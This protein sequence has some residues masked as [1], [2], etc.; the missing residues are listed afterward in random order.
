MIRSVPGAGGVAAI[1]VPLLAAMAA[2]IGMVALH[3]PHALSSALHGVAM[4]SSVIRDGGLDPVAAV[5]VMFSS[6][7]ALSSAALNADTMHGGPVSTGAPRTDA[8]A[9]PPAITPSPVIDPSPKF[10][11]GTGEGSAG[12]WTQP[13]SGWLR[14]WLGKPDVAI[15]HFA[16]AMRLNPLDPTIACVQAGLG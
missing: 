8:T 4:S 16:R 12:S 7:G 1:T 5:V 9:V 14:V 10:L 6:R 13:S 15:E 3:A 2:V 11:P